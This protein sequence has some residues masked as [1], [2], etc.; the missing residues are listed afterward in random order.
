MG[1][2]FQN[3]ELV[4][5]EQIRHE[6]AANSFR[7]RRSVGGRITLTDQR[8]IFTPNRLDGLTGARRRAIQLDNIQ[9]L[10]ELKSGKQAYKQRG[11]AASVRPQ[12]EI[13][14]GDSKLVFTVSDRDG[15]L[16]LLRP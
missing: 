2:W 5:G 14:D 4:S 10:R 16:R 3:V 13:S 9:H 7:G 15:L 11:L 8:L 6:A 12:I 1:I